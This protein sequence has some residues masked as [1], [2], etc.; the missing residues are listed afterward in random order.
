MKHLFIIQ[1]HQYEPAVKLGSLLETLSTDFSVFYAYDEKS[2]DREKFEG[3]KN[4][5]GFLIGY[6]TVEQ[7]LFHIQLWEYL[8]SIKYG[9]K[10]D[11]FHII[12]ASDLPFKSILRIDDLV[13]NYDYYGYKWDPGIPDG[14]DTELLKGFTWYGV[15]SIAMKWIGDH[16]KML[17]TQAISK[18]WHPYSRNPHIRS[19]YTGSFDEYLVP[20]LLEALESQ[21]PNGLNWMLR[22]TLFP[23]KSLTKSA[24][25]LIL[26]EYGKLAGNYNSPI[27]LECTPKTMEVVL[28]WN[29]LYG[30]KFEFNSESYKKLYNL[31]LNRFENEE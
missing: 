10:F 2:V 31:A 15:S 20:F 4:S 26:S 5:F 30:R 12:S 27:T 6:F 16:S 25:G 29:E 9:D 24:E 17:E 18:V 8:N 19:G 28:E 14:C 22:F 1:C 7:G 21:F 13:G 23:D 3:L 11:Y